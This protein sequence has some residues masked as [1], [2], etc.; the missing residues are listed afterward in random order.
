MGAVIVRNGHIL[1][2]GVNGTP[3]GYINCNNKFP[4]K[5]SKQFNREEHHF[6]SNAFELHAEINA[7]IFASKIPISI[8]GS[9]IYITSQPCEQCL[10]YLVAAGIKRIVYSTAYD[11]ANWH[12][13]T[14]PFLKKSN[15]ALDQIK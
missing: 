14:L 8:E 10:K 11:K 13:D 5:T 15:V 1:S 4:L 2:F 9:T 7:A 3:P 12:P 6:W